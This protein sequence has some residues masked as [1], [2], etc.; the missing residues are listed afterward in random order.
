MPSFDSPP[1]AK[2]ENG[3]SGMSWPVK[4]E[5]VLKKVFSYYRNRY[6]IINETT[7]LSTNLN[8]IDQALHRYKRRRY[9]QQSDSNRQLQ[10]YQY[11]E[12]QRYL[13]NE[14]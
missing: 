4:Y 8:A 1:W 14:R 5:N 13:D 9:N 11:A 2:E 3:G 6:P 12:L 10:N 7:A